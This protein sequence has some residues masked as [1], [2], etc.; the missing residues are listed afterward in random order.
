[1]VDAGRVLRDWNR[2]VKVVVFNIRRGLGV[3]NLAFSLLGNILHCW[4]TAL[5]VPTIVIEDS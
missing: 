4:L 1:M 5:V 2:I 3:L